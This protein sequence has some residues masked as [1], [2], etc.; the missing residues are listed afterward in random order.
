MAKRLILWCAAAMLAVCGCTSAREQHERAEGETDTVATEKEEAVDS[1]Y[2]DDNGTIHIDSRK[3]RLDIADIAEAVVRTKMD[4]PSDSG[5]AAA[6][7]EG[8]SR[9]R[10]DGARANYESRGTTVDVENGYWAFRSHSYGNVRI[11]ELRAWD[12]ADKRRQVVAF[13]M[14]SIIDGKY[15]CVQS[16]GISFLMLDKEQRTLDTYPRPEAADWVEQKDMLFPPQEAFDIASDRELFSATL[17]YCRLQRKSRDI[18]VLP[19]NPNIGRDRMRMGRL[20][21]D[22]RE[23]FALQMDGTSLAESEYF[24]KNLYK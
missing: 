9:Y 21:W 3:K 20:V 18:L 1:V 12:C 17:P 6:A 23:R 8:I 13:N 2:T 11:T 10:A 19:S 5:R 14:T 4:N 24:D 15:E 16:D 7:M 22:G